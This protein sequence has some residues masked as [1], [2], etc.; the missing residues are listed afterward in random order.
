MRVIKPLRLSL[1]QRVLTVR[2][3]HHLSVGIFVYFPFEA[4]EAPLFE[5]A[6]WKQIAATLRQDAAKV[7]GERDSM[8]ELFLLAESLGY[9]KDAAASQR[10]EQLAAQYV[11]GLKKLPADQLSAKKDEAKHLRDALGY[12]TRF[13]V[14]SATFEPKVEIDKIAKEQNWDKKER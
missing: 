1:L 13:Q 14:I 3:A 4:P 11:A 6:M 2:R 7:K 8:P 9:E 10:V 5:V 12:L